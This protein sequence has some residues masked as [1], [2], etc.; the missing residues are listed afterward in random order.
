MAMPI[1]VLSAVRRDSIAC[2]ESNGHFYSYPGHWHNYYEIELVLAGRGI[3]KING[4]EYFEEPGDVFIM[5]LNDRHSFQLQ[6]P[7]DHLV[8][9]VPV[10]CIPHEVEEAMLMVRGNVITHL[11]P[12]AFQKVL[13][14]YR[15]LE[16]ITQERPFDKLKQKY[17]CSGLIMMILSELGE[18]T[19]A[20]YSQTNL[21]LREIIAYIQKNIQSDLSAQTI[22]DKFY[23]SK[24]YLYAFFKKNA[25]I[26]LMEYIRKVRLEAALELLLHTNKSV[27][28]ISGQSGFG[29]VSTFTR[30]FKNAYGM[31]PTELRQSRG[32][33]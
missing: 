6:E 7:G 20:N 21:R 26:T 23:I 33:E 3:H 15:L 31:S 11:E 32:N 4:R 8:V 5:R 10:K 9:D 18:G 27:A 13:T 30:V 25:G 17:L 28:E 1:E 2:R 16:E 12:E 22:A 24:E 29:A 19:S 14:Q